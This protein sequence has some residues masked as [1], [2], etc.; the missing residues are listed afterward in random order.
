MIKLP[1]VAQFCYEVS[2]QSDKRMER[3]RLFPTAAPGD[4]KGRRLAVM[5]RRWLMR[6]I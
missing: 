2:D 5:C 6:V 1:Q 4:P 3:N